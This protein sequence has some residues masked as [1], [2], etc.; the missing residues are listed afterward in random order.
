M[1]IKR[2]TLILLIIAGSLVIIMQLFSY[3][4]NTLIT[5][6]ESISYQI[7]DYIPHPETQNLTAQE[8]AIYEEFNQALD[9]AALQDV[10][11]IDAPS[12]DLYIPDDQRY[13]SLQGQIVNLDQLDINLTPTQLTT[14]NTDLLEQLAQQISLERMI[15]NAVPPSL[16]STGPQYQFSIIVSP[17]DPGTKDQFF[18]ATFTLTADQ[19]LTNVSL[20]K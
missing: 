12:T 13:Q 16:T 14:L 11:N 17:I 10:L 7:P 2:I 5:P 9:S 6:P 20:Q 15:V 1:D 8:M 4:I 3:S 18:T 19:Q